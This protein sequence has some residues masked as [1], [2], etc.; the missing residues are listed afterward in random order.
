MMVV[1]TSCDNGYT[2]ATDANV[3]C[4]NITELRHMMVVVTSLVLMDTL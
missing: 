1:V 2:Q 3:C 4:E